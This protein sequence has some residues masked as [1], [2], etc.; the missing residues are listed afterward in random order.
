M[1][2]ILIADS[3]EEFRLALE[4]CLKGLYYVRTGREGNETLDLLR[5]YDPDILVLDLMLPGLDGISLLQAAAESGFR[6]MVL[7]TTRFVSSYVLEAA[8]RLGIGYLMV[9]PCDI[10]ATVA[11]IADLGQRINSPVLAHPDP[12]SEVSNILLA[13]NIPTKLRG[14][15]CVREAILVMARDPHQS[16]TK[17]VYPAVAAACSGTSAQVERAIRSAIRASWK[18]RS[19]SMWRMYFPVQNASGCCPTNAAFISRLADCLVLGWG[20]QDL[21]DAVF[22]GRTNEHT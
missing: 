15:N 13:L 18:N 7:A 21:E 2:K 4:D 8:D 19:E 16:V 5:S 22:P 9:K 1:L 6:P 14:Y 10:R 3:S 20:Q 17:E 12:R 11:R